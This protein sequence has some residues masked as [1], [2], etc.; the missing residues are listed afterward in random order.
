MVASEATSDREHLAA[1]TTTQ[2]RHERQANRYRLQDRSSLDNAMHALHKQ[3]AAE[4][5]ERTAVAESQRAQEQESEAKQ[6]LATQRKLQGLQ[7]QQ[8]QEQQRQEQFR[9][10]QAQV[11]GQFNQWQQAQQTQRAP[12]VAKSKAKK[13]PSGYARGL[14]PLTPDVNAIDSTSFIA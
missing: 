4:G 7:A 8:A 10:W 11:Q 5:E 2:N 13:E 14:V 1:R 9:Q 6:E 12:A 3:I